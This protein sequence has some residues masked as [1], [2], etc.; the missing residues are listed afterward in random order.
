MRVA[1]IMSRD[2]EVVPPEATL[3]QA[4]EKMRELD[5]GPLPVFEGNHVIGVIT[6]RDIAVRAVAEGRDPN[7]TTVREA[8]TE[9]LVFCFEDQDID[10]VAQM[11]RDKQI[12]RLVVFDRWKN[13]A[14]I[15]SLGDLAVETDGAQ[16]AGQ[17]LKDVS[18]PG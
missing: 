11:M 10:E 18:Q 14:G 16:P 9:D 7:T 12:R 13:L 8:M 4:A 17:V 2:V 6:D 3:Q 1:D 15:V 5:I